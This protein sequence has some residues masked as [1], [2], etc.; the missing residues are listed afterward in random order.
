ME[1]LQII[2]I[3]VEILLIVCVV[4]FLYFQIRKQDCLINNINSKLEENIV[5]LN[6][7][8]NVISKMV[9]MLTLK[10]PP[11]PVQNPESFYNDQVDPSQRRPQPPQPPQPPQKSQQSPEPPSFVPQET[12]LIIEERIQ[13]Q[14]VVDKKLSTVEEIEEEDEDDEEDENI[15]A[16]IEEEL[17]DLE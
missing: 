14:P 15:D 4:I 13:K 3:V 11:L 1:I 12:I 6:K 9:E 2:H 16:E 5:I 10:V 7:H 17:K 8:E